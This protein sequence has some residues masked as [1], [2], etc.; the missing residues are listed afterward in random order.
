MINIA[1]L[2]LCFALGI[3]LRQSGRLPECASCTQR[4]IIN[5]S[6]PALILLY[7]HHLPINASLIYPIVVPW[8]L[9]AFGSMIFLTVAKVAR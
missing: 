5:I 2:V 3:V 9:F 1:L 4:L 7:I 6:L 8:I